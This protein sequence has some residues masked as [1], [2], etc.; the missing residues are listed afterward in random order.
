[1][2]AI[3]RMLKLSAYAGLALVFYM[4]NQS[5]GARCSNERFKAC[6]SDPCKNVCSESK[7]FYNQAQIDSMHRAYILKTNKIN[8]ANLN[9]KK[10]KFDPQS[11]H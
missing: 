10:Y 9:L 8:K 2:L 7:S 11:Y 6:V 5:V 4:K 1:M 3:G